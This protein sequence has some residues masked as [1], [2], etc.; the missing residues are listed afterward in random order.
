VLRYGIVPFIVPLAALIQW[1]LLG[2]RTP[3]ILLL[4]AIMAIAR[5][6]GL[7][8][9]LL[10]TTVAALLAAYYF[11]EP[12][13]SFVIHDATELFALIVFGF[14]GAAIS[15]LCERLQQSERIRR[16][17]EERALLA[18]KH[19]LRDREERLQAI[20]DAAMDAIVT[21]DHRGIIQSVNAATER[22]FGYTTDEMLGQHVTSLVPSK[23]RDTRNGYISGFLQTAES[24]ILGFSWEVEARHKDGTMFPT[25]LAVSE[26]KHLKL[27]TGIYHDLT[28][29]KQLERE[30]VEAA[31]LEQRR[32][33]QDLHDSVAQELTA[34]NLLARDLAETVQSDPAKASQ[35]VER[36]EQ[37]LQRSQ[38]ELRVVLRGLLPVA[39]DAE[40]LMA[41]LADLAGRTH[42][43]GKVHCVFDCPKPV[44]V[45]DNLTATHLYLVAQE[46]VYNAVKHS[47]A[48]IILITLAADEGLILRVQDDGVGMA[49][50]VPEC[51]GLGLRIVRNRAAIIGAKLTID[52]AMPTGTT[53]SCKMTRKKP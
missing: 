53:V 47:K 19:S 34:L 4:P 11:F 12:R 33:G 29:R 41:A 36:M 39:V 37:G 31:A 21:I 17:M 43:E 44:S 42:Q 24:P 10:A 22:M 32:I 20:L 18:T 13:Y 3:F 35:L 9:G 40:G 15:M 30:V 28:E 26:I 51:L 27:F 2:D 16:Q 5:Y 6:G 46:A 8:P 49:A 52:P 50:Q 48:R 45:A 14:L 23:C 7:G 1:L 38:R 25:E